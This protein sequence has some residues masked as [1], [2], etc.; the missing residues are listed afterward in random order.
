MLY[1]PKAFFTHAVW[2]D[3]AFAHCPIFLTAAS[4]RSL[5]RISVPVWPDTL[6]GRLPIVALVGRYPTNKLMGGGTISLRQL[7]CRG[8]LYRRTMRCAGPCGI[9]TPLGMLSPTERQVSHP[10]LTRSPLYSLPEGNFLVR[11]ACLIHAAS[12]RSEPGSNSPL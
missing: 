7:T 5:G 9:S 10:L 3:Q 8:H 6:S 1:N 4:R 2:L 11:L 12:V